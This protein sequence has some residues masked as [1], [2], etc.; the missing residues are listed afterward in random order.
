MNFASD[1][2]AGIAPEILEAI[3]RANEGAALGYGA[4][5]WTAA[6][7]AALRRDFRARR[8]GVPGADRDRGQCAGACTSR[9]A[10]GR[11]ALSRRVAYRDRRMRR[12]GVL[13]R[14]PQARRARRPRPQ[15]RAGHARRARSRRSVRRP[16][17]RERVR[18]LAHA[19]DRS[20]HHLSAG[21]DRRARRDRARARA[22]RAH[23][24][25]AV[26][27]RARAL[28]PRRRRRPGG[29]ASTYCRSA[30][31]KAARWRP[32]PSCSSIRRAPAH[33]G[34][35]KR[36]GH[37]LSKHRFVAA[38]FDASLADDLWLKLARHANAMADRLAA[39]S[40]PS[41]SLRSGRSKPTRCSSRCRR[42]RPAAQGGRSDATIPG[43]R[44]RCRT[45]S[46]CRA[47]PRSCVSSPRSQRPQTKSIVSWRSRALRDDTGL[48]ERSD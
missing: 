22:G 30:P 24:R 23:R 48:S 38:Q 20:R 4:D 7:R 28:E 33:A 43:P 42:R 34:R 44:M 37:L 17:S 39:D 47:M 11:R 32:K 1:N 27:Q 10:V 35:R 29:P 19:G 12:A 25:R 18:A 46:R 26:R 31:P 2:A 9:A 41:V 45:V 5:P 8:R 40:P 15:D 36:A 14:R 21:R 16:A 13:R 6:R 3:A